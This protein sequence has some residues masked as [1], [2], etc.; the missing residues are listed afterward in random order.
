MEKNT[1]LIHNFV[2][3]NFEHAVIEGMASDKVYSTHNNRKHIFLI[4]GACMPGFKF[5]GVYPR[6][7]LVVRTPC[8]SASYP[9]G[10][11]VP[12]VKNHWFKQRDFKHIFAFALMQMRACQ[13]E[14][15]R[16]ARP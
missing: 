5:Q 11:R 16:E 4:F 7:N 9:Q 13:K 14:H 10:V 1:V 3:K 2:T 8:F 12:P 15:T 6:K